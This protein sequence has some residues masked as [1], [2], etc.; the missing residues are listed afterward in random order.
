[1]RAL[2]VCWLAVFLGILGEEVVAISFQDPSNKSISLLGGEK[3][4]TSYAFFQTLNRVFN[5][6]VIRHSNRRR[7][8]FQLPLSEGED[9]KEVLTLHLSTSSHSRQNILTLGLNMA[10]LAICQMG[11]WESLRRQPRYK[12]VMDNILV[13]MPLYWEELHL[14]V[15]KAAQISSVSDLVGKRVGVGLKGSGTYLLAW[16]VLRKLGIGPKNIYFFTYGFKKAYSALLKGKLDAVFYLTGT[17]QPLLKSGSAKEVKKIA[18][19]D[20]GQELCKSVSSPLLYQ[21]TVIAR[22]TYSFQD[23]DVYTIRS[24]L[25]LLARRPLSP[26]QVY[27]FCQFVYQF[28]YRLRLYHPEWLEVERGFAI[29]FHRVRKAL[30]TGAIDFFFNQVPK[31]TL[32]LMTGSRYGTYYTFGKD[33]SMAAAGQGVRIECIA[34]QGSVHNLEAISLRHAQLGIAQLDIIHFIAYGRHR[35]L[36]KSIRY[37][38][39]LYYEEIHILVRRDS[40][41]YTIEDMKGK[42]VNCGTSGSG[43]FITTSYLFSLYNMHPHYSVRRDLS[44]PQKA[45]EKLLEGKLD[46][47]FLVGGAPLKLLKNLPERSY[48]KIRFL[49]LTVEELEDQLKSKSRLRLGF[50]YRNALIPLGAYPWVSAQ[51]KSTEAISRLLFRISIRYKR[52]LDAGLFDKRLQEEFW[53]RKFF[54]S[55][56]SKIRVKGVDRWWILD[57][58]RLFELRRNAKIN[59]IDVFSRDIRTISVPCILVASAFVPPD[60]VKS[61]I[62][63]IRQNYT[64]FLHPKW[65]DFQIESA[66]R[67]LNQQLPIPPHKG[68]RSVLS[69]FSTRREK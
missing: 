50:P 48:Q 54:L 13:A 23:R 44:P 39:P 45:L 27:R 43:T 46:A 35:D 2:S 4:D 52:R 10:D 22:R 3:Y 58:G 59:A 57:R 28:K 26:Y 1:M 25:L 8:T 69:V 29:H 21:P 60:R 31:G 7:I 53:K 66:R 11:V 30:H 63:G 40:G 61:V 64:K 14:I 6:K 5:K 15:R 49:S 38:L 32:K 24:P 65:A 67:L 16:K 34:S 33:I 36:L 19:L 37:V 17:P 41:I 20:L 47:V 68:L 42:R 62:E 51:Y 56:Q 9:S 18:L 12:K 55:A